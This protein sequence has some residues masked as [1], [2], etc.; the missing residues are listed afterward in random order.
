KP[1]KSPART[2]R[3]VASPSDRFH[4]D[5]CPERMLPP[6]CAALSNFYSRRVSALWV[7]RM[8]PPSGNDVCTVACTIMTTGNDHAA[9]SERSERLQDS[10]HRRR[11]GQGEGR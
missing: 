3:I 1:L 7:R 4:F 8:R 2:L 6:G 10:G 5:V 9:K 11:V